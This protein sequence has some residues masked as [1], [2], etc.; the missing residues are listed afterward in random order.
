MTAQLFAASCLKELKNC[1]VCLLRQEK[2]KDY[3]KQCFTGDRTDLFPAIAEDRT[4]T[5]EQKL[6]TGK[7]TSEEVTCSNSNFVRS[8]GNAEDSAVKVEHIWKVARLGRACLDNSSLVILEI[9][10]SQ[11]VVHIASQVQMSYFIYD[12]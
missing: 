11:M 5:D 6:H 10:L 8:W 9:I 12:F 7:F 4:R 1:M 2:I 3:M